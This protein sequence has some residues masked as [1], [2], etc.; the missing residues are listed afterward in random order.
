MPDD[1]EQQVDHP[2]FSRQGAPMGIVPEMRLA[3][4]FLLLLNAVDDIS[5]NHTCAAFV[6]KSDDRHASKTRADHMLILGMMY[7]K[8]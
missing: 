2:P 7:G 5:R 3:A 6:R 1:F 4:W 8:H